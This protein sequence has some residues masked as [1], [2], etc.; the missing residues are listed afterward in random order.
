M[1]EL[2]V[3]PDD[4]APAIEAPPSR[5]GCHSLVRLQRIVHNVRAIAHHFVHNRTC[6]VNWQ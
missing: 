3:S 5:S 1:K 2:A 6:S 4:F